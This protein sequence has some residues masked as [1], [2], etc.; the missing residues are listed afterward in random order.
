MLST[1]FL[2]LLFVFLPTYA[3]EPREEV[4]DVSASTMIEYTENIKLFRNFPLPVKKAILAD[5]LKKRAGHT[6]D[7][8]RYR[9]DSSEEIATQ[10][11][12]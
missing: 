11:G 6:V 4:S 12:T 1:L 5:F 3:M 2:F 9:R 10:R 8:L 7:I